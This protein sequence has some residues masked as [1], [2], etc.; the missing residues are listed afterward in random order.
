MREPRTRFAPAALAWIHFAAPVAVALGQ[1]Q[2]ADRPPPFEQLRYEEDH[3]YLRDPAARTGNVLSLEPIKYIPLNQS[4]D[5][6]LSLGGEVREQYEFYNN[7][8]FGLAAEDGDGY[9]LQRYMLHGDL[10]LGASFR[11]FG[12]LK[13]AFASFQEGPTGPAD[14]DRL[15]VHQAFSDLRP[16][17]PHHGFGSLTLRVGR[18]EML[19]G[20][21]R[22]ISVREGPNVRRTFD[23]VRVLA[24]I[25]EWQIDGFLSRPVETDPATF[26]DW[27][28]E[29]AHFWGVYATGLV[30]GVPGLK[31]DLY[32]LGLDQSDATFEQGTADELRHSIGMRVFGEAGAFDYNF[33][34]VYQWGRFGQG[35][36]RAWTLASDT[37]YAFDAAPFEPRIAIR[38]DVSS[39]DDDRN[40]SD[41]GTFSPLFPKGNYFGESAIIG[42]VNLIDL[43]PMVRFHVFEAV[44]LEAGWTFFWRYSKEDGLY[45]SGLNLIQDAAGSDDRYIGSELSWLLDWQINRHLS[46][47]SSCSHFFAGSFLEETGPGR[48]VDYFTVSAT[49][50]F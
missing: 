46:L 23:A 30:G 37:G 34:G 35:D 2:S 45:G 4:G 41:L 36:I 20:S 44:S 9:L 8:D 14:E 31:V 49:Y 38:T 40:D 15:D 50:R 11:L 32:Y 27:G 25:D 16:G 3:S 12:Q 19:Y 21:Q 26:D 18:Q 10:H 13:S 1:H 43:H 33:E 48:D 39:G 6:H 7:P 29:G 17:L 24:K 28:E 5:L 22:L 42:P 47:S